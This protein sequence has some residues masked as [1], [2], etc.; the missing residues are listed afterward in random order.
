MRKQRNEK[1]EKTD[2]VQKKWR[3]SKEKLERSSK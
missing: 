3:K 2:V 1:N